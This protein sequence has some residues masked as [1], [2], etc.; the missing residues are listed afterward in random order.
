MNYRKF[1]SYEMIIFLKK[2]KSFFEGMPSHFV[3]SQSIF[4]HVPKSA[5]MSVVKALYGKN[6]S[7]HDTWREYYYRDRGM[8]E[9]FF[10]FAFVREPIDRFIS[11]YDYLLKGGKSEIDVYWRDKYI[12]GYGDVNEFVLAGGLERAMKN[13][14]EHFIPQADFLCRGN[15]LVMDFVARYE[16]IERDFQ[17]ISSVVGGES[18]EVINKNDKKAAFLSDASVNKLKQLYEKDFKI[19]GY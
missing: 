8:F 13:K 4:I 15:N 1:L 6:S 7:N 19:F 12:Y 2:K 10:K 16:N 17:Y 11:A 3:R 9:R 18:L 14:A 5:G